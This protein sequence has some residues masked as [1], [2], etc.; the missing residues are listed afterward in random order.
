M[1]AYNVVATEDSNEGGC[2]SAV[3]GCHCGNVG[4]LWFWVWRKCILDYVDSSL[5]MEDA[6][7]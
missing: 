5:G 4:F 2:L 3:T 7:S 1:Y 6:G